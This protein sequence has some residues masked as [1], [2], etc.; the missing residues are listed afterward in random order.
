MSKRDFVDSIGQFMKAAGHSTEGFNVRQAALYT[1]LQCEELAEKMEALG[2][3]TGAHWLFCLARDF[4]AGELDHAFVSA[5]RAD[6]L[7]ADI[8]LA[9]VSIGAAFSMGA[10]V[11]GACGEVARA[12]LDKIGPDGVMVKDE[13]GKVVKPDGWEGPELLPFLAK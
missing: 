6:L 8:D 10:D 1:G 4:K 12:N 13:N 11:Q 9:W 3:N 7:D 5:N 2:L